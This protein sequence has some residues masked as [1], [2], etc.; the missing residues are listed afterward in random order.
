MKRC[1]VSFADGAGDYRKKMERLKASITT[2]GVDFVGFTSVEEIG[3]RPHSEIPYQ[4][5]PYAIQKVREMGYT[6]VLW[7]DSPIL[8]VKPLDAVFQ[9]IE[10]EGYIF[11]DNVGHSLGMWTNEKALNHFGMTRE[12]AMNMQMIMACCMGFNFADRF[13]EFNDVWRKAEI[14]NSFADYFNLSD[15][16]YPG[17]WDNHRHDQTV[18]SFIIQ[19]DALTILNGQQTFFMYE[20][21]RFAVPIN[22]ETICLIS[23]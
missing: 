11:F 8:A 20:N 12:Q 17:S 14:H 1:V 18:M 7:A 10:R 13:D 4:F 6:S 19:R 16:L 5:K 2:P 3:A 23:K 15:E 9:H 22:E 21:H